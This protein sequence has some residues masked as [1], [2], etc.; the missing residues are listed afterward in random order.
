MGDDKNYQVLP[1]GEGHGRE[2]RIYSNREIKAIFIGVNGE[3][4]KIWEKETGIIND[5]LY[6]R[7]V[8]RVSVQRENNNIV[9]NTTSAESESS[10]WF[11]RI[12]RIMIS[13]IHK[14][15]TFMQ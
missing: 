7:F 12:K 11:Y 15:K 1:G 10:N 9:V 8:D 3:P 4:V 14:I 6:N 13:I 2:I 5:V